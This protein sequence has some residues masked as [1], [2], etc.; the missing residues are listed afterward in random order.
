[1]QKSL[2]L[3][4]FLVSGYQRRQKLGCAR[5]HISKVA[6]SLLMARR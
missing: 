4:V 6:I 3:P 1:M 5:D 2:V